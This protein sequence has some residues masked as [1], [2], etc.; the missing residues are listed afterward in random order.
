MRR[1]D[2]AAH[3]TEL[4]FVPSAQVRWLDPPEL[5]RT[6][7]KVALAS[8][9]T[10]YGDR[11][12][13]QAALP[14]GLVEPAHRP[15][16][17]VWL[18]FVADLGD[19]FD[20][21][22]TVAT[23]LAQPELEVA[24]PGGGPDLA[25]PR[26]HVLVMGGD[27]VYPAASARGYEHRTLGPYGAA[28][29]APP[30]GTP[31]DATTE[32]TL[33]AIPG[34][35][36]WYDGL[37]AWLRVF[38]CGAS[39]GAWRTVQRRSYFAVR[40][41]PGWWLLGLDSQLDEYVDGPQLD[42][43]RTHV[44]A[45]LRPGDA[46]VV[47]AAEPAWAKAGSDPDA[48]NQLHF[49]EREV[50]R[51][52]RVPGRREPEETGARVRLWISGDSHHYSRYAERPP[53]GTATTPGDAR[54][55]QAVTCG[56]GGAYLG[57]TL[58]L[59][60]AVELPP[61]A[62]RMRTKASPG[63]WF[64]RAGPTYPPQD[65][66]RRLRRRVA[67]PASR[68]WAGRRNPG[69]LATAGVVQLVL[70][71]CLAGVLGVL[72]GGSPTLLRG[73]AGAATEAALGVL[74]WVVG[75]LVLHLAVASASPRGRVARLVPATTGVGLQLVAALLVLVATVAVPWPSWSPA[76]TAALVV[77]FVLVLGAL[78]GTQAFALL[79]LSRRDGVVAGWQM[80][81]QAVGDGK[82]FVRMC[83]RADGT[84]E[85]YPVV[86]DT[87]CRAWD[88]E[89]RAGRARPVPAAGLPAVRLLEEPV[90]VAREGFA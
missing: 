80:S 37:T 74:A 13:V 50:V 21:T 46:V 19:G 85:L 24:R 6:A 55:V 45:H 22:Y 82:G 57:D 2:L 25:L 66:S 60:A 32:P 88:V 8:V 56:L 68:W 7:L 42:Y 9:F 69:L 11:R 87:V 27:E 1:R 4:G 15:T 31:L 30:P 73:P 72:R 20:A 81:G 33:L 48:F 12:E 18:D 61:A 75:L 89:H 28:L 36:D 83:V 39:V 78:L 86:V 84:L 79:L 34:N 62:S 65:E 51:H 5:A 23:L 14:G 58:H 77:P 26:G 52:R 49:V 63:T 17:D 59:P 40:L 38:T 10:A 70:V 67:N 3:G 53:A 64:D 71:G 16:G 47:C 43:F 90:V 76:L 41:A 29:P 54:A 44:T 35:H